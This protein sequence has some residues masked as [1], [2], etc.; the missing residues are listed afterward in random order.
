MFELLITA[1]FPTHKV[2]IIEF[3]FLYL[4]ISSHVVDIKR[5]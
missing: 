2:N 4:S 5:K 3:E 1:L